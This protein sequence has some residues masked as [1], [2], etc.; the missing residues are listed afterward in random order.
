MRAKQTKIR[1]RKKQVKSKKMTPG[2]MR[3]VEDSLTKMG[4]K[5]GLSLRFA[6]K[7]ARVL[8]RA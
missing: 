2:Q 3:K 5:S 6:R 8:A 1:S 4:V 7:V